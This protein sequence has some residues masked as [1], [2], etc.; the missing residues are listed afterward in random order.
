[1]TNSKGFTSL[2]EKREISFE[3]IYNYILNKA[4]LPQLRERIKGK[5]YKHNKKI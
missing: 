3:S 4:Y 1:M 5:F 2:Y